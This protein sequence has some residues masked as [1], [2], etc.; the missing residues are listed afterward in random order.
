MR[1]RGMQQYLKVRERMVREQLIPR[2]IN[3]PLVLKA[4]SEVPRHI[5]VEDAL[6]VQAYGDFPLPI[7]EGQ[8]ISQPYIVA[9]MTE[10]LELKGDEKVLEIG[11]G[12]GYQTAV[13][14]KLCDRV[15]SVERIKKL[16]ARARINLDKAGCFNTLCKMADGTMGWPEHGPYDGI[17]VTAGGPEIPGALIEQLAEPGIMVIPV[18]ARDS[19]QLIRVSKKDG[20]VNYEKGEKVRFVSLIGAQGWK[21][22]Q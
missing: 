20:R 1:P 11:T 4:I 17:I 6:Q 18:G 9:L 14:A 7:G 21:I 8:T 10:M 13:L 22:E 2:G 12:C 19:Q 15:Y 3:D 5:F 16:M